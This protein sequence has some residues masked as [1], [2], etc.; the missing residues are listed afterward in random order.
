[1]FCSDTHQITLGNNGILT[2]RDGAQGPASHGRCPSRPSGC[3]QEQ[4]PRRP[5]LALTRRGRQSPRGRPLAFAALGP[6]GRALLPH[7]SES[8]RRRELIIKPPADPLRAGSPKRPRAF[9]PC[10]VPSR[11]GGTGLTEQGGGRAAGA[12]RPPRCRPTATSGTPS[13]A[14]PPSAGAG[15]L[16][17][18]GSGARGPGRL[19]PQGSHAASLEGAVGQ[20]LSPAASPAS[21]PL[22]PSRCRRS[23]DTVSRRG[24]TAPRKRP[25]RP[26][27]QPAP[28]AP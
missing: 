6:A 21:S 19:S 25:A 5:P 20:H 17:W 18:G 27:P 15:E 24:A 7:A 10:P 13:K 11:P 16:P 28:S 26:M 9:K 2:V 12:G 22:L 23:A 3:C 1:M 14:E 4:G 8:H